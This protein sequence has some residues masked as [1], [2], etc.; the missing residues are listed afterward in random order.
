MNAFLSN[1]H[2]RA[3]SKNASVVFSEANDKRV[4]DAAYDLASKDLCKVHL[5]VNSTSYGN[6]Y[7]HHDISKHDSIQLHFADQPDAT[8]LASMVH[9]LFGRRKSK[10]LTLDQ[11]AT[12]CSDPLWYAAGLVATGAVDACVAGAV[13]TTGDV[14]RAGIQMIGLAETSKIVSG[15]FMMSWDDGRVFAYADCAVFPYPDATQLATIAADT[16]SM[17]FKLTGKTPK[18]AF[19]SFATGSSAQH[20][21]VELVNDAVLLFREAY[22]DI[23][24]DGPLQFDAALLPEIGHRKAPHSSVAGQANVFVFPNLDAGNI[25]YKITERL[26]GAVATGPIIQGLRR[27]MNDLSR[28]ASSS[29]IV[30]TACIAALMS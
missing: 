18:V 14:L 29:D 7:P 13:H 28:G 9:H 30:D 2:T 12:L 20:E 21:R 6:F 23:D 1:L 4:L 10:G 22:P 17:Y 15:S 19:L 8:Q 27:P 11:A 26:G 24:A 16:A 3:A 5:V 25:S